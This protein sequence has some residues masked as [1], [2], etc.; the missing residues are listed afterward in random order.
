MIGTSLSQYRITASLGA[1]GMGEVF[2]AR[3]T[4]L[5]REVAIKVLPKEFANDADRL[6]RFEQESKTLAALNHP[7][8]LTIYDADVHEGAPY[9]VSELLEGKTLR[10]ELSGEA[11]PLRK[12]TDYALQIAHGLAA[13]HTKGIIHRDLKPENIFITRD[14]RVKILDFG[15]AKLQENLKSQISNLKSADD[16][17][18]TLVESTEPGRVMGTPAYMS[19]EQ[20]RGESVDHRTDIFAFGCVLYEMLSGTRAFR[21]DTPVESM[22]AILKEEPAALTE[23]NAHFPPNLERIVRR[24]LE[25]LPENRFQTTKDLAFALSE[26]SASELARVSGVRPLAKLDRA[27]ALKLAAALVV[28]IA[29]AGI[30]WHPWKKSASNSG[31][32]KPAL[33][34]AQKLTQQAR[35]LIDDNPLTL[36]ENYRLAQ[37][38]GQR[39]VQLDPMDGEAWATLGRATVKLIAGRYDSS[40]TLRETARSQVQRALSL[41]PDSVEAG[42]AMAHYLASSEQSAEAEKRL[43]ALLVHFPSDA[44]VVEMLSDSVWNQGRTEESLQILR[45]HANSPGV[46]AELLSSEAYTDFDGSKLVEA[47][48]LLD[49]IFAGKPTAFNYLTR[50]LVLWVGWGDLKAAGE[51]LEKMPP[52]LLQ[53]DAFVNHACNVWMDLAETE[54]ALEVLRQFP[55]DFLEEWRVIGPKGL[56]TGRV[57][58]AAGRPQAAQVEWRQALALVEQRLATEPGRADWVRLKA[59]LLGLLGEKAEG[60]KQLKLWLELISNP[61]PGSLI[62]VQMALGN[63]EAAIQGF[64]DWLG[65]K[66]K[67][68]P[69]ALVVLRYDPFYAA[70]RSDPRV[71]QLITQGEGW[72]QEMRDAKERKAGRSPSPSSFNDKKS[73]AVL[74]FLNFSAD[75]ADEYLSDGMTEELL[76]ALARIKGLRVPGRSSSFAF[77][78]K[79]EEDIFRK[80]GETLHVGAVLEGSVRKAG[81]KLRITAQLINVSDGFHLWSEEYDRDMTNIFAIQSDIAGRVAEAL[82]VQLLG[83]V[84]QAKKP[85]ESL[86]AYKLY[87]QGRQLW[88]RRT[89]EAITQ[90]INCFN[91]AI[92]ADA[93]YALAYSGLADCYAILSDYS[94]SPLREVA[95]KTRAA[96]LKAIEL[97]DAL[98]EPH[99][100]LGLTK[101]SLDWDWEG[102]EAEFRRSVELNPNYATTHHWFGNVLGSQGKFKESL[103]EYQRAQELD[104]LSDMINAEVAEGLFATGKEELAIQMLQRQISLHSGFEPFH[105]HLGEFYL[106]RGKIPEAIQELETS[107]EIDKENPAEWG[108]RGFAYARA[109]RVVDAQRLLKELDLM[110]RRGE[111]VSLEIA[112]IQ[113]G[114]GNDSEALDALEQAAEERAPGL[115]DLFTSPL[116]KDL[117]AQPR[118][119]AILRKMNL[120]K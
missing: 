103:A 39:A 7:N 97:D 107:L 111:N 108:L 14:G 51:F 32:E 53:E 88:N 90:A 102:A 36:R 72:L 114:L 44:R 63:N 64:Q 95:P 81:D 91:Q 112:Y 38:L 2:R 75:K 70:L 23:R 77:K 93:A 29:V 116:W 65:R 101:A 62:P 27:T 35:A 66:G 78:G 110:R 80:V 54:K 28:G 87:L 92:A 18:P 49:Q 69:A 98:G 12:S 83:S 106:L 52:Q 84:S 47:D 3:D 76:N 9:L 105:N 42:L 118:A 82:K 8:V 16:D 20:V 34:E 73:V 59:V 94:G 61:P 71:Q 68:W 96:A 11:L 55:R 13:A 60:E 79:T 85:T 21:R 109:G 19:P 115:P 26:V 40:T 15:L 30:I 117:H 41:V 100:A 24:C 57:L 104:P 4:R 45:D 74:P 67:R 31:P 33:T 25:K 89:G 56:L 37:E 119:Q 58:Q 99:A 46:K 48:A 50:L 86:E 120:V 10:E 43:R 113:H 17:A 5:N 6:R 22:H 1:G